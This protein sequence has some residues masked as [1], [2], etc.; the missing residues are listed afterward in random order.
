MIIQ[1]NGSPYQCI[2]SE[3]LQ[4]L[5][6]ELKLDIRKLAIEINLEII[7]RSG[8]SSYILSDGDQVEIV[9]FIGGGSYTSEEYR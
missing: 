5:V 6:G 2:D 1:L 3:T 7:P 8:Y 4:D 9:H